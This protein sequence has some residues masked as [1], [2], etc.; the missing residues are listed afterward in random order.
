MKLRAAIGQ[1]VLASSRMK[2]QPFN[3]ALDCRHRASN[4]AHCSPLLATS[5][6]L[7]QVV[8]HCLIQAFSHVLGGLP[9]TLCNLLV[10]RQCD[11]HAQTPKKLITHIVCPQCPFVKNGQ[12]FTARPQWHQ[13]PI[14]RRTNLT[15]KFR[16][17]AQRPV[18]R[19][20]G[21]ILNPS[22]RGVLTWQHKN[23]RFWR[24]VVSGACRT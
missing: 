13:G 9:R 11:I 1:R 18:R 12:G 8:A 6:E 14:P 19:G 20:R 5:A 23:V 15:R 7:F 21:D 2:V 16:D 3:F 24:E 4:C 17:T 22:S 10:D